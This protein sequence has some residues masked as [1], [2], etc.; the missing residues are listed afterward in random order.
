MSHY[1]AWQGQTFVISSSFMYS[2][3]SKLLYT[4]SLRCWKVT[5]P[6]RLGTPRYSC[7]AKAKLVRPHKTDSFSPLYGFFESDTKASKAPSL[8]ATFSPNS[9]VKGLTT[10]NIWLRLWE[11]INYFASELLSGNV[12]FRPVCTSTYLIWKRLFV[13]SDEEPELVAVMRTPKLLLSLVSC[14]ECQKKKRPSA[15]NTSRQSR[16]GR[17]TAVN[18]NT[19]PYFSQV[20]EGYGS[21]ETTAVSSLQ[22]PGEGMAGT[23]T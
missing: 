17:I 23:M 14:Q 13:P 12:P 7:E 11:M 19:N 16:H 8:C 9:L 20:I 22:L 10:G 1:S 15:W 6:P 2:H 21:T 5:V 18:E 4:R 3:G